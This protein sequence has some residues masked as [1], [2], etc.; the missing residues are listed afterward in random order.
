MKEIKFSQDW[1]KKL[2]GSNELFTTIRKLTSSKREYY[3]K[4]LGETFL[5]KLNGTEICS[6]ELAAV[7]CYKLHEIPSIFLMLDTGYTEE[8]KI[9]NLF[10]NFGILLNDVV[11]VLLFRKIVNGNQKQF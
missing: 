7:S 5:V 4:S 9:D 10:S 2:T 8:K 6:A 3:Y 1:N 11:L